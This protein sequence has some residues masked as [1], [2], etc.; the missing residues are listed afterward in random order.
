[1]TLEAIHHVRG[2]N[3]SPS[4]LKFVAFALADLSDEAGACS[5]GVMELARYTGQDESTV[6]RHLSGLEAAGFLTR[7]R[8]RT[9]DG[10]FQGY[11]Y[12]LSFV[13]ATSMDDPCPI[14]T[15]N[16]VWKAWGPLG[17]KRSGNRPLCHKK[18]RE[19][20]AKHGKAV[21]EAG[22]NNYLN[23][24]QVERGYIKALNLWLRDEKYLD[25]ADGD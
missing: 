21:V 16:K 15:F 5:P 13:E 9:E 3:L 25:W 12:R 18:L 7:E 4:G 11:V 17:R 10:V 2:M 22:I 8:Q 14:E 1:M 20:I 23:S 19:A 24:D 6:R